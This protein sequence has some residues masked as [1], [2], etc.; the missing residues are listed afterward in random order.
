VAGG[1]RSQYGKSNEGRARFQCKTCR[2]TFNERTG[3][4]FYQ[5]KTEEKDLL[6][7]RA[8]LAE[9][10]RSSSRRRAQGIQEAT[11]RSF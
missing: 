5:R 11:I 7:C 4:R 9:G 10:T 1:N 8:R 6:E 2:K 3:T